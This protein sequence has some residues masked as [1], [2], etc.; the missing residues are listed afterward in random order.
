MDVMHLRA[1]FPMLQ[2]RMRG[3]PL[4][5]FDSA[6]TAQK[7]YCVIDGINDFYQ[8]KYGTV[9]RAVYELS[10][11]STE[12]YQN[13]RVKVQSF[14]NAAS[15][16]EIVYTRG[17]TDAINLVASS[18][19]EAFINEGDC[20]LV[21]AMEHHS[22]IVPW[23]LVC[24]KRKAKLVVIPMNDKG[25]LLME[26]YQRLLDNNSVKIVAVAHVSNSLGTV[27]PIKEMISL[28]HAKGAKVLVDGAQGAP[29]IALDVQDLD[30]DFYAFSGHKIFGP[31]GIGILYGKLDLL[32]K[33]PPYQGG[34]DMIDTVTFEKT[35]YNP[36]PIKFEAGTP[37][38]AEVIGLGCAIDYLESI[39]MEYVHK[40]EQEL[41]HYATDSMKAI[42]GVRIIGNADNKSAVISFVVDGIHYL[43][44]GTL[45]DLHGIA[46]RTGALCAQPTM[47][48]F[49]IKGVA[50]MS[51]AFY[52]TK[53]EIDRFAIS[54]REAISL[55]R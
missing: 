32:E 35:T 46:I 10:V 24:G 20:V 22:N 44:I 29:H 42:P 40:W 7:P 52:N 16:D 18:F 45:L 14:I 33:M 6:A 2:K 25:E 53:S 26:E 3:H 15:C 54:L 34:G 9:H 4:I 27:N 5:Y 12:M 1:D 13:T 31:T 28:A 55:L 30:V 8:N 41:L 39:G 19:G 17:T 36:P 51:L 49:G 50:R 21:S 37:M 23:Q 48:Y 43:D 38:I 47:E 11:Y